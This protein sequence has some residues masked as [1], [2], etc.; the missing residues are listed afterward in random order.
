M[1]AEDGEMHTFTSAHMGTQFT[2]KIWAKT[3]GKPETAAQEAFDRIDQLEKICSDYDPQSELSLLS[4]APAGKAIPLS[5]DLWSLFLDSEKL[6]Q[7]SGGDFDITLG[8]MI[9]LWRRAKKNQR[10]P[11]SAQLTSAKNRSGFQHLSLNHQKKTVTKSVDGMRLDLGGI[12]K[13]YA[14][15]AALKILTDNGFPHSLVAASG[16]IALGDPPPGKDGWT[17][18]LDTLELSS[19]TDKTLTLSQAAIST[20]GDTRQFIIIDDQRYSHI[21]D[22]ETG[23]G[24]VERL[25]VSIRAPS[26]TISDSYATAVSIMGV[27][28]GLAL[29]EKTPGVE[30][31]IAFEKG[32]KIQVRL[33]SGF[34]MNR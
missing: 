28:Q 11:N 14:A 7:L 1:T 26:A 31:R 18:G 19:I 9:D 2:I 25:S 15:D 27:E 13:G 30:C 34:E 12:A 16:D 8:P 23:L 4:Q 32:D 3:G 5:E 22:P 33:S 17:V 21:V 29:I 24:L 10:L 20:S 6:Y